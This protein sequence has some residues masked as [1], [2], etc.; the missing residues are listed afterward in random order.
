MEE[1]VISGR[2]VWAARR[3]RVE[4]PTPGNS[5]VLIKVVAVGLNPKDWKYTEDCTE[6]EA[7]NA[8]D[9]IAGIVEAVGTD[10]VDLKPGDRVAGLHRLGELA[11][12]YAEYALLPEST[13]FM[14]PPTISFESGATLP[15][16]CMTAAIS[17]FQ[18][19]GLPHCSEPCNDGIPILIYGGATAVG[20][21]ALQLAG[22]IGLNPII[23]IAG[24]GIPFVKSLDVATHIIDYRAGDAAYIEGEI[25]RALGGKKLF[26]A[27]DCA[28][29]RGSWDII[30]RTMSSGGQLNMLDWGE[31]LDWDPELDVKGSKA[32]SPPDGVEL[33]FT[34]VSSAYGVKHDWI[35]CERAVS[36]AKFA[37]DFYRQMSQLLSAGRLKPH[38][39]TV[40][41]GGLDGILQGL[42]DLQ[43]GVVSAKKLVARIEDTI[44]LVMPGKE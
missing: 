32:W 11:G 38:P 27:L 44:G 3:Q 17:L 2:P 42:K 5:E 9:D 34:L 28:C 33:S 22:M 10:V 18:A 20:A 15:L 13:F 23:T 16:A 21:F 14:L 30:A 24:A 29:Q 19:L 25:N 4:I 36:D 35:S 43:A 6:A 39:Y 37:H 26:K 41:S 12:G 7:L 40:L 1:I 8:G 31:V